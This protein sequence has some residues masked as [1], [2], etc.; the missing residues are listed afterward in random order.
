MYQ[1]NPGRTGR[2]KSRR[3]PPAEVI[4]KPLKR[5]AAAIHGC[6]FFKRH[7][8]LLPDL[9][10]VSSILYSDDYHAAWLPVC[11]HYAGNP[12]YFEKALG[13]RAE[14]GA[15]FDITLDLED[16]ATIGNEQEAAQWAASALADFQVRYGADNR[17]PG[18]RLHPFRHPAFGMELKAVLRTNAALPAYLMLPKPENLACVQA[19]LEAINSL[20]QQ[21]GI[22][23]TPPLHVL[24]ETHGALAEV[25][26]IARSSGCGIAV[27]LG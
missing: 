23:Q 21:Q 16:G 9:N 8:N 27:C 20:C 18:L 15:C 2:R 1:Q 4:H 22:S 3:S 19:A 26:A 11:D 5:Q 7:E 14:M 25:Q 6:L 13:I 17:K 10:T 12:K 24:I